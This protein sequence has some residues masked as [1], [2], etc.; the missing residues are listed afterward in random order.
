MAKSIRLIICV[1][2]ATARAGIRRVA[3]LRAGR[4]SYNRHIIVAKGFNRPGLRHVATRAVSRL[5]AGFRAGRRSRLRPL[6]E[7]V[8][9]SC[10]RSRR[11]LSAGAR[12][13]FNTRFGTGCRS[14]NGPIRKFMIQ[15]GESRLIGLFSGDNRQ[16]A[17]IGL[18][19][20]APTREYIVLLLIRI[21]GRS[22]AAVCRYGAII[23]RNARQLLII[24]IDECDH[25]GNRRPLCGEGHVI[26][27]RI[28]AARSIVLVPVAPLKRV[29]G[30]HSIRKRDICL[31]LG[32]EWV[33]LCAVG[34]FAAIQFEG[35][36]VFRIIP[37]CSQGQILIKGNVSLLVC[38]CCAIAVSP[39]NERHPGAAEAIRR[40]SIAL[41]VSDA[42]T[43]HRSRGIIRAGYK[44][45]GISLR[46][47]D[48]SKCFI[49]GNQIACARIICM[50]KAVFPATERI[51]I[52]R[53]IG[54][55]RELDLLI[56]FR[57]KRIG[58]TRLNHSA[59]SVERERILSR[60]SV[61]LSSI[62]C[63]FS[64]CCR[65]RIP[66][67][68]PIGVVFI[69]LSGGCGRKREFR[70]PII[71]Y[72]RFG[73]GRAIPVEPGDRE[74]FDFPLGV[75]RNILRHRD[76][77]TIGIC[78]AF[79][80]RI[81]VPSIECIT[82]TS[83]GIGRQRNCGVIARLHALHGSVAFICIEGHIV[84]L[85]R[86]LKYGSVLCV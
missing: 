61:K 20:V 76:F 49:S 48:R 6:A 16:I 1:A 24:P 60:V 17:C 56:V 22:L 27:D 9:Q 62:A 78:R 80:I 67:H 33:L 44:C 15:S 8:A 25:I 64:R 51:V 26:R 34:K 38:I 59:V 14:C 10:H 18:A 12:S 30:L 13:R 75:E 54:L 65:F 63:V 53:N 85:C 50:S 68:K 57:I 7:V 73:N 69:R 82:G 28:L 77:L 83:K 42:H 86:R 58:I 5:F 19:A 84:L 32:V 21:L 39:A 66:A 43:I 52:L 35:D 40:Q 55:F 72:R 41:P 36:T 74:L 45:N 47:P 23:G 37:L 70:H 79:P 11:S 71:I 29:S 4:G 46:H 31:I 81:S 3:A 2:V